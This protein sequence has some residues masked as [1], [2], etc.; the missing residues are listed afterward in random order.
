MDGAAE[1]AGYDYIG[2]GRVLRRSDGNGTY[3]EYIYDQG[4]RLTEVALRS[5]DDDT[6]VSGF[7]YTYDQVGNARSETSQPG[8]RRTYYGYDSLYQLQWQRG[9]TTTRP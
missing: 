8:S 2:A 7:R 5:S 3:F 1:I 6:P 9:L 4:R